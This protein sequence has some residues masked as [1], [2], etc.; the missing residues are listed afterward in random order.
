MLFWGLRLLGKGWAAKS[1]RVQV[2][3]GV[4][5]VYPKAPR[6]FIVDT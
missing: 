5:P 6:T 4:P 1:L 3:L 2:G